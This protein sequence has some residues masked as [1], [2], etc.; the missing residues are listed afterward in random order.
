MEWCVA[1]ECNSGSA[2]ETLETDMINDG[3]MTR[4]YTY[5]IRSGN[6]LAKFTL[7]E[8][9]LSISPSGTLVEQSSR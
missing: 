7:I 9:L 4:M 8:L 6:I 3:D 2:Q 5:M 1:E